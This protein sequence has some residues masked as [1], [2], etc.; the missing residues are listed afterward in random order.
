MPSNRFRIFQGAI[1]NKKTTVILVAILSV[2]ISGSTMAETGKNRLSAMEIKGLRQAG[3]AVLVSRK[4]QRKEL[5]NPVL[6][7]RVRQY[8]Q[9]L[10]RLK[11]G[12]LEGMTQPSALSLMDP[13]TGKAVRVGKPPESRMRKKAKFP[14][15]GKPK[16]HDQLMAAA[17]K[18]RRAL[19]EALDVPEGDLKGKHLR[20]ANRAA[21]RKKL[22]DHA[23]QLNRL[24]NKKSHRRLAVVSRLVER[25]KTR[26]RGKRDLGEGPDSL[27]S[28]GTRR[29][30]S[31]PTIM[32]TTRHRH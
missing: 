27:V 16:T 28:G 3:Q 31:T 17:K 2:G 21:L 1:M 18:A 19:Y 9:S 14:G 7:Q 4:K 20:F 8:H 13:A 10:D 24:K 15:R 30:E 22:G 25:A 32:T 12:M 26:K 29:P 11:S 6:R 23:D 5:D